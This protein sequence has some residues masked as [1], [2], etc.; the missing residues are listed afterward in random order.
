MLKVLVTDEC[1]LFCVDLF[2]EEDVVFMWSGLWKYLQGSR[3]HQPFSWSMQMVTLPSS[4]MLTLS[5]GWAKRHSLTF[6]VQKPL[7]NSRQT[8]RYWDEKYS[9]YSI[10]I[11]PTTVLFFIRI[12]CWIG[13]CHM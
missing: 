8:Y 10:P 5:E 11:N 7:R 3:A 12:L 9:N 1:R 2:D 6:S 13:S 4:E